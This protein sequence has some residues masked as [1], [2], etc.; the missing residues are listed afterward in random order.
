M[1][2]MAHRI[3]TTPFDKLA[4][5]TE[6]NEYDSQLR[7]RWSH[8][9]N[10]SSA[11][12]LVV[13]NVHEYQSSLPD[14]AMNWT[15][16]LP[17]CRP[18]FTDMIIEWKVTTGT[19]LN[20]LGVDFAACEIEDYAEKQ[21]AGIAFMLYRKGCLFFTD[22]GAIVN[23][24]ENGSLAEPPILAL[25]NKSKHNETYLRYAREICPHLIYTT[26]LS[27]AF[28]HC[29]NVTRTDAGQSCEPDRPWARKHNPPQ[30]KYHV[31]NINPMKEVLRTEGGSET[32]GIQKSLHICRGHFR[33]C[34]RPFGRDKPQTMWISSHTRGKAERG[35]V[36]KDYSIGTPK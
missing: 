5:V 7:D 20:K 36:L 2:R 12:S 27:L 22:F 19:Y 28:C 35:I 23:F 13:D 10:L 1:L 25:K 3:A 29:K 4:V 24:N 6:T 8:I 11:T 15:E 16:D 31:L 26:L 18:I 21:S 34:E 30:I 14:N 32:N 17:A 9:Q 33:R